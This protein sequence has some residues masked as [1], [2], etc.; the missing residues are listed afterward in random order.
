MIDSPTASGVEELRAIA[1]S[2]EPARWRRGRTVADMVDA[3]SNL[4]QTLLLL[5][6]DLH[7]V[8]VGHDEIQL[9]PEGFRAVFR[10]LTAKVT[11]SIEHVHRTLWVRGI[12][13]CTCEP[14]KGWQVPQL[15]AS[16]EIVPEA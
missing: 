6:N 8:S 11:R 14:V 2:V 4:E 7:V 1:T 3:V 16:F 12:R 10:G 5:P 13:F 9:S 15:E